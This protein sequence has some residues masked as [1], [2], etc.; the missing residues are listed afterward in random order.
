MEEKDEIPLVR[1]KKGWK[2]EKEEGERTGKEGVGGR[3][4]AKEREK[5][6]EKEGEEGEERIGAEQE[7]EPIIMNTHTYRQSNL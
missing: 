4:N 2:E 5:S 6:K 7:E 3:R 1:Q